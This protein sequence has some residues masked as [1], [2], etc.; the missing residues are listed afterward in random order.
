[1]NADALK[2]EAALGKDYAIKHQKRKLDELN[3]RVLKKIRVHL[4]A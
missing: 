2:T 1:M 4:A 3:Y